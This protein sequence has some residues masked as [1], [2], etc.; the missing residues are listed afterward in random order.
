MHVHDGSCNRRYSINAI[1]T[2]NADRE[3]VKTLGA[4]LDAN[5]P[6]EAPTAGEER[7]L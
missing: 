1:K 2:Q 6:Q 3:L 7:P 4:T 5:F